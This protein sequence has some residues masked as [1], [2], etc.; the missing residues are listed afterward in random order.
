MVSASHG[1]KVAIE[2]Q[3]PSLFSF[4]EPWQAVQ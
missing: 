3:S 1:N 4:N 2:K